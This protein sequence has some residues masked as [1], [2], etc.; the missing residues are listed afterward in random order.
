MRAEVPFL[1]P[2][3]YSKNNSSAI[4]VI[5]HC[6]EFLKKKKYSPDYVVYLQPTSPFRTFIDI[7]NGINKIL[8]Y[9]TT[10][11]VGMVKVNQ[12]PFWMFEKKS[13]YKMTEFIKI[14]NK[15]QRRQDLPDLYYVNDALYITK[16]KYFDTD[17]MTNPIFD[18]SD[19]I[20]LGNERF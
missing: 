2:K 6:L 1:R 9:K 8:Y 14:K 11:L 3:K 13:E 10:S 15:P 20:L 19:M 17:S 18:M 12:H 7:N 5:R 16:T 4:S